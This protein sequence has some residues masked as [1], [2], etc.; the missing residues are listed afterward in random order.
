MYNNL[1]DTA[2][3]PI[4]E[5]L[6]TARIVGQSMYKEREIPAGRRQRMYHLGK[7][8]GGMVGFVRRF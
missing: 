5:K 7:L 4:R 6:N 1:L 8:L 2:N 3:V